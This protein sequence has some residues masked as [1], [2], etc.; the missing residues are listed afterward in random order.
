METLSQEF[1]T[2]RWVFWAFVLLM[3]ITVVI[4]KFREHDIKF[5]NSVLE[6]VCIW[7]GTISMFGII[8]T[9]IL[10]CIFKFI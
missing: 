3:L 4:G 2:T 10:M 1:I 8:V 6:W 5:T 9:G 7:I